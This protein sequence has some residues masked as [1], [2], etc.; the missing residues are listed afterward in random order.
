VNK[1]NIKNFSIKARDILIE[2]IMYLMT[3]LGIT[4]NG[5]AQPLPQS[6]K[7]LQLFDIGISEPIQLKGKKIKQRE[8]LVNRIQSLNKPHKEAFEFVVEEIAYTWFNRLIAIRFMEINDYLPSRVRVLSS[9]NPDKNE[10]DFVTK[11]FETDLDFTEEEI[12]LIERYQD[13]NKL[14]ELFRMLFIKQCNKLH[15]ILPELFEKINDYTE[16]FLAI[17]FNDKDG[18]VYHLVHDIPESDFNI[19]EDGQIE[20]IGWLYQYYNTEPKNRVFARPSGI[21]IEAEEIPYATQLFTPDWIVRYMVQNSLGRTVI[22]NL[23]YADRNESEK[24]KIDDFK[25]KWIY[26]I[27]EAE[28]PPEVTEKF[29]RK[30]N[31]KYNDDQYFFINTT[32]ID[33]CM[34]SGHILIYAF[35]VFMEIYRSIGYT[36]RNAVAEILQKN[37]Y[38]L[39]IDDRAKQ[40]AY[41]AI[42]MKARSYDRRFFSR[43]ITPNLCSIQDSDNI[44]EDYLSLFGKLNFTAK[45]LVDEFRQAKEYGSILNLSI[46]AD[47]IAEL[48]SKYEEIEN[49]EYFDFFDIEKQEKLKKYF[50][51]LIKQAKIMIR[52]YDIV[53]TNPPYAGNSSF[54]NQ[55]KTYIQKHY[56]DSKADLFAVFMEKCNDYTNPKCYTAMITMHSWMFLSSFE[57]L[58]KKVECNTTISM[59]HFGARAFDEISGEVVQTTAFVI[60]KE[61]IQKYNGTYKRLITQKNENEK[62]KAFL[63]KDYDYVANSD[64]F[65]K[66]PGS[67]VAYW[68]SEKFLNIFNHSLLKDYA[69]A[70]NGFTTGDNNKF[71]RYWFEIKFSKIGFNH[72]SVDTSKNFNKKWF[73]YN[74]GGNFRKWYGNN[75]YVINWEDNG[76]EIKA[77]GHLVARSIKHQFCESITWNKITSGTTAFRYKDVGTMFD[78]GGLSMFPYEK[79]YLFYLMG[80]CNSIIV[81]K[82]LE[83]ISPTLNCETGHVSSIPV[84]IDN[85]KKARIDELVQNNIDRSKRDWDSFETSWD[86]ERSSIITAQNTLKSI[87]KKYGQ[88]SG[89]HPNL[90]WDC[91]LQYVTDCHLLFTA[92]KREEEELNKIFIEIYGLQDELT[93]EIEYKDV[94]VHYVYIP[95]KTYEQLKGR[96]EYKYIKPK[97]LRYNKYV[98]TEQSV[99][100]DFVSYAVGCMFGRYSLNETGLIFAGGQWD[101]SRYT[102]FIP[103]KDNC[104]PITDTQYFENDIVSRFEEFVG[105]VFG[106][107]T[108]TQNLTFIAEAL[109]NKG[110]T[111]REVIRNY[112]LDDFFK[113]HCKKYQKRPIY[114]LFDSGKEK[115]FRALVYMHRWN[116][117]TIGHV[118]VE[119]LHRVQ[120]I[121]ESEIA[122]EQDTIDNTSNNREKSLAT[123]RKEKLQKQ[124]KETRDYDKLIANLALDRIMIDLDDGVKVNYEKVQT[125]HDKKKLPILA[126]I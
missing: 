73:P 20:I 116:A 30:E 54:N 87:V 61:H 18:I 95:D 27:D 101:I 58:R 52:K 72:S 17:D 50:P 14:N 83:I 117:D 90:I 3:L 103:T 1:T 125:A 115:G 104:I 26:Y 36:D 70:N 23:K 102:T 38:G 34:G 46:T 47:K 12:G 123:K 39:E 106:K 79:K 62:R 89:R 98:M 24:S 49:T 60:Q 57:K 80:L 37:L 45:Q 121:Y 124:L 22:H 19:G 77:Y 59:A 31:Q 76:K 63:T 67:P 65:S 81:K 69:S 8:A 55:L 85:D 94:T 25:S 71:L 33:P 40:L 119:Y 113:D 88:K 107:D 97:V 114:W 109:G 111:P 41:F 21:K 122:R 110:N 64:N 92:L 35:D 108:L 2:K 15:E 93:P 100:K 74:K 10:P 96:Y 48:E 51:A 82:Y 99:I 29:R 32:F 105:V 5:I 4:E 66:I 6:T 56:P 28:Q 112:F 120:R 53:C 68:V 86:F 11:P 44:K 75:D 13:E 126:K 91:Y 42:M 9:E 118:R 16:L 7:D 43:G 84:I 78:V